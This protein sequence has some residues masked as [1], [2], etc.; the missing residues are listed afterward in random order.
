MRYSL[1]DLLASPDTHAPFILVGASEAAVPYIGPYGGSASRVSRPGAAVGP[2]P[3]GET[4]RFY[5]DH[6]Q[7]HATSPDDPERNKH[8]IVVDG[9]LVS[10]ETGMWYP[11][12]DTIPEILPPSLRD[13]QSH[14]AFLDQIIAPRLPADLVA[15]LREAIASVD[16]GGRAGDTYKS[17]E[18]GLLGKVTNKDEFLGPGLVSPF[19]PYI[20]N[21]PADLIRGFANCL[22]FLQL[23]HGSRVLDSGSGYG[24][25]PE[26]LMKLGIEAVGIDISRAYPDIGRKRMGPNNQPHL[27]IG[28]S[29]NLPFRDGAFDAVL[30]FD[31]FHHIPNRPVAMRQYARTLKAD[32]RVVLVEPGE[33]HEAAEVSVNVMNT[34]GIMEVG[35]ERADLQAYIDGIDSF[36]DVRQIFLTPHYGDDP[37]ET[38]PVSELRD[39]S[40]IGWGMFVIEKNVAAA[41]RLHPETPSSAAVEPPG[42]GASQGGFKT[43]FSRMTRTGKQG[44][45]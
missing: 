12:V 3:E 42:R 29:E 14:R 36:S 34:Y 7:T 33:H 23:Q 44:A 26:W 11:V 43:I 31:A 30:C 20:Y 24:W 25:T 9:L 13:W 41:R 1:L 6:L 15:A 4:G 35:M 28:D 21:H 27:V 16:T 37:R 22:P 2:A 18:I 19:N 40:Y 45:R 38:I 17:S 10:T 39:R 8:T 32:G 5:V